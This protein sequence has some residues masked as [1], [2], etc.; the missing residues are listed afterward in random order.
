MNCIK[1]E[2]EREKGVLGHA[3]NGLEVSKVRMC[4]SC[5]KKHPYSNPWKGY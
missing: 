2:G 5:A 4:K 1:C 3:K